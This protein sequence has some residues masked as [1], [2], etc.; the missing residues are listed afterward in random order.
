MHLELNS[1]H[2]ALSTQKNNNNFIFIQ[3]EDKYY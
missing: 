2:Y 3:K 1:I